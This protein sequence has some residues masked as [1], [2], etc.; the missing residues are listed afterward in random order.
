MMDYDSRNITGSW[1]LDFD[2]TYLYSDSDSLEFLNG[3]TIIHE[4][5]SIDLPPLY[6]PNQKIQSTL[7]MSKGIWS[8]NKEND[9][10][11]ICASHHPFNGRYFMKELL[12]KKDGRLLESLQLSNDSNV[13]VLYRQH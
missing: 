11:I 5:G 10:I 9:S 6:V 7:N 2:N 3:W 1:N 4:D 13:I 12:V 8:I